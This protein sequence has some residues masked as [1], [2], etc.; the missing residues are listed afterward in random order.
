MQRGT[1]GFPEKQAQWDFEEGAN[2]DG[3][4]RG[5]AGRISSA[6][7]CEAKFGRFLALRPRL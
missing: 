3:S 7:F 6:A 5:L 2:Q 4:G 1:G